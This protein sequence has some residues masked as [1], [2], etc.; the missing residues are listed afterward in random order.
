[1]SRLLAAILVCTVVSVDAQEK[2]F[3]YKAR[4]VK[5]EAYARSG[6]GEAFYPTQLLPKDAVVTVRRHDPGGW[7]MIDPP[8]GSFSWIPQ[9]H[10]RELSARSG[11]VIE[12][13]VV[14]FVGS[15][16]G[17]ETH[18]WQRKLMAGDKV[19]ILER[20]QVDTLSGPKEMLRIEPPA[21]EYR[22]VPGSALIPDDEQRR[23]AHDNNPYAVPA[24][25][26]QQESQPVV[27][28]TRTE[29][30]QSSRP[31]YSP[32][33]RLA[34]LKQIRD[35]QR[36]LREIDQRFRT[37][38]LSPPSSWDL[39]QI[40]SEYRRLQD[41]ATYK[42]VAGQIDLRYPAIRR[43]EKKK[44]QLEEFNQLTSETERRDAQLLAQQFGS[45]SSGVAT[46]SMIPGATVFGPDSPS[47]TASWP[48]TTGTFPSVTVPTVAGPSV[49]GPSFAGPSATGP[50]SFNADGAIPQPAE[51]NSA[52]TSTE[53]FADFA[54]G[55]EV[56][57]IPANSRY[58]G[59]GQITRGTGE[60][61]SKFLLTSPS[62]KI[63]AQ[64]DP[65]ESVDL[66]SHVGEAVGLHG[67]RYYDDQIKVDRIEVSGLESVRLR[68]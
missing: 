41:N 25:L 24:E 47:D 16:F 27:Q 59:A 39:N 31:K 36:Q 19:T 56:P 30:R 10:V 65:D 48:M 21:R 3:P 34:Q 17:D 45:G 11:E 38:I 33:H 9:K 23:L 1:M 66:E 51:V 22:W 13:N 57:N 44:A 37:M 29:P 5:S 8:K 50:R 64:L 28:D 2:Q 62:G 15:A 42:P 26:A 63:L 40:E 12:S 14:V 58:I 32:S 20:R 7:F 4:V 46:N 43:Y 6:A 68:Q 35:E 52:P 53:S 55:S 67:S 49:A 60:Y 61:A 18:V 54:A